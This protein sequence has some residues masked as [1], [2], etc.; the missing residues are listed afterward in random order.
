MIG[1]HIGA[2]DSDRLDAH[3]H[4]VITGRRFGLLAAQ[5]NV[6]LGIDQRFHGSTLLKSGVI[7]IL[8]EWDESKKRAI[9]ITSPPMCRVALPVVAK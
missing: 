4:L 7:A 6:R 8:A 5:Q 1:V 3:Q 2:A 9:K